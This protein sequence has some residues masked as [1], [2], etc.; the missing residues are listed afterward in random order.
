MSQLKEFLNILESGDK[1]HVKVEIS[2]KESVN[3]QPLTFKQQKQ[4]VTTSLNGMIGVMTFLKN[5]NEIILFNTKEENLKIYDRIP[6]I[7]ALRREL[8]SKKIQKNDS[9]I[10]VNDLISNYR[11]FDISENE[12]VVGDGY[13]IKLRV[14]TLEQE[15]RLIATCIE[16]LKKVDD[17]NFSKNISLILS[18]EIPKY[19]ESISFGDILIKMDEL[20]VSD[21]NKIMDN[22]PANITNKIT[23]YIVKVRN[24][25]ESLLTID[26]VTIEIDSNFFE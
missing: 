6:I 21:R 14:P 13:T 15:N 23:D 7:L 9:E 20:S 8:T 12:E 2:S 5:L 19:M 3:L 4:L 25:D 22:I 17:E 1:K 11:K 10:D 16:D 18:Y 24:Y 26:G